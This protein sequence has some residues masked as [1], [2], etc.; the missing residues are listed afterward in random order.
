MRGRSRERVS[1][2]DGGRGFCPRQPHRSF[3]PAVSKHRV[4]R[5][6]SRVPQIGGDRGDWQDVQPRRWKATRQGDRSMDRRQGFKRH[7]GLRSRSRARRHSW[8][9]YRY[10]D[11]VRDASWGSERDRPFSRAV[12]SRLQFDGDRNIAADH[13]RVVDDGRR[14]FAAISPYRTRVAQ[15]PVSDD[16]VVTGFKRLVTFYFTNFPDHVTHFYLRKVFE[17]CGILEHVFVAKKLNVR[18]NRY[19]FVRFSNVW[20]VTKLLH[21]INDISFGHLRLWAK[22]ARF[23]RKNEKGDVKGMRVK[24]DRD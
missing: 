18:G 22:V 7:S 8:D 10:H 11:R 17:V 6:P 20:D 21:A 9:G 2:R 1:A 13:S 15:E 3:T 23:D 4:G 12:R 24:G 5:G 14:G 16:V 19:G